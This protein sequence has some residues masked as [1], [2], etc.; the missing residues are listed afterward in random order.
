MLF[1]KHPKA[2][3]VNSG[4]D[5]MAC[6]SQDLRVGWRAPIHNPA[7]IVRNFQRPRRAGGRA[8]QAAAAPLRVDPDDSAQVNSPVN[9]F[10]K[11][12]GAAA[13][14]EPGP[15]T[16][17]DGQAGSTRFFPVAHE[18]WGFAVSCEAPDK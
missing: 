2:W 9:A 5:G 3:D 18:V 13:F 17:G 8:R 12:T 11:T 15:E 16:A 10:I 14:M 6:A 1:R 4:I 7:E